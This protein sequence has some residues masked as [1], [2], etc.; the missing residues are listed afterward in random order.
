MEFTECVKERLTLTLKL[1]L[2]YAVML[3]PA[4]SSGSIAGDSPWQGCQH[5]N[6]HGDGY[7][8][9]RAARDEHHPR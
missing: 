4:T 1:G 9:H 7:D 8:H 2:L 5:H 3:M 6:S